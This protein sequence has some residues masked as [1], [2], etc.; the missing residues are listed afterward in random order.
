MVKKEKREAYYRRV[1]AN[2][3]F[4]IENVENEGKWYIQAINEKNKKVGRPIKIG[5]D[6]HKLLAKMFPTQFPPVDGFVAGQERLIRAD[7]RNITRTFKAKDWQDYG[8]KTAKAGKEF[9]KEIRTAGNFFSDPKTFSKVV[10]RFQGKTNEQVR[11]YLNAQSEKITKMFRNRIGTIKEAEVQTGYSSFAKAYEFNTIGNIARRP[12]GI[13]EYY[14]K[15]K[16]VIIKLVKDFFIGQH[17]G[18]KFF[19]TTTLD[20][21]NPLKPNANNTKDVKF[22]AKTEGILKHDFVHRIED[23]DLAVD[24]IIKNIINQIEKYTKNGSGFVVD[25][26]IKSFLNIGSYT[27]KNGRSFFKLDDYFMKRKCLFIPKNN[28]DLCAW[29]C[30]VYKFEAK[31][32]GINADRMSKLRA[33]KEKY[34]IDPSLF[35]LEVHLNSSR[36]Q[37][38]ENLFKTKINIYVVNTNKPKDVECYIAS[39]SNYDEHTDLL[40]IQNSESNER[41]FALI[42]DYN[43][44]RGTKKQTAFVCRN[45]DR[46][47]RRQETLKNHQDLCL[48]HRTTVIKMP[49]EENYIC[50]FKAHGNKQ[51]SPYTI[52]WDIE[53]YFMK[54]NQKK[55]KSSINVSEHIPS[56]VFAVVHSTFENKVIKTFYQRGEKCVQK[57]VQ[58]VTSYVDSLN[59]EFFNNPAPIIMTTDDHKNYE[60]STNCYLCLEEFCSEKIFKEYKKK[61]YEVLAH[62]KTIL[63]DEKKRKKYIKDNKPKCPKYKVRDHCHFTGKYRGSA[64]NDC[65]KIMRVKRVIP[66]VAHNFKGYDSHFIVQAL[67]K[68]DNFLVDVIPTNTEK[69]LQIST[70]IK[71]EFGESIKINFMDSMCHLSSSL[72]KLVKLLSDDDLVTTKEW[73]RGMSKD[74]DDFKVKF[75]LCKKKGDFSY[76]YF[77]CLEKYNETEIPEEKYFVSSLEHHG[78]KF[79]QLSLA[80]QMKIKLKRKRAV[81]VFKVF[82]FKNLWE[83]HDHYMMLD[84]YLLN[85]L[86]QAHRRMAFEKFG[87]D[88]C[89][90]PTL[91]SFCWDAMLKKTNVEL[92]LFKDGQ[93]DMYMFCER[94]KIGGISMVGS[95]AYSEA[96]HP[97]LS[98][99]DS[100]KPHKFIIYADVNGLYSWAMKQLLPYKDFRWIDLKN[101]DLKYA[102]ENA[103][104]ENGCFLDIDFKMPESLKDKFKCYPILPENILINNEMLS[105]FQHKIKETLTNFKSYHESGV[106]KLVPN[107]YDKKNYVIHIKHLKLVLDICG[108]AIDIDKDLTI[109][110]VLGFKQKAWLEPYISM[111]MNERAKKGI[112]DFEKDFW[113]LCSNA[114]YG[115]TM[116]DTRDRL[117]LKLCS[118]ENEIKERINDIRFNYFDILENGLVAIYK[119]KKQ[120]TLN[121]PIYAGVTVLNLSKCLMY[122][123]WYNKLQ[124]KY[125]KNIKLLYTDTDSFIFEVQTND[126]AKDV[127]TELWDFSNYPSNHP[128]FSLI[129]KKVE[130]KIKD[131]THGIPMAKL[132]ALRSKSYAFVMDNS[133]TKQQLDDNSSLE[134]CVGKGISKSILKTSNFDSYYRAKF[135]NFKKENMCQTVS[136]FGF[137]SNKHII[138]TVQVEK[139]FVSSFDDKRYWLDENGVNQVPHGYYK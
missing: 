136:M 18:V 84:V 41:H 100:N 9:V 68:D 19:L 122:D 39:R 113:K 2:K 92:E 75:E 95:Q 42:K 51:L 117:Y 129:N 73:I 110:K 123:L 12:N 119:Y 34:P 138:S 109:N 102:M 10:N 5:A 89:Y 104:S 3:D 107:L 118:D 137:Q 15:L 90:Y 21:I 32:I 91:P 106:K 80:D 97:L 28:D 72:D 83:W 93:E 66:A 88:P 114:V 98:T 30:L 121:K 59:K 130:G 1:Y 45:C 54:K 71:Q 128:L 24:R 49:S 63:N 8:F 81:E 105:P 69:F 52:S 4:R 31:N 11:K 58:E 112:S 67:K 33:F 124:K 44:F 131:E 126:F 60:S 13:Y 82:G 103:D 16:P 43:S 87:L 46:Q 40:L 57:F 22:R 25:R 61:L 64:C 135:H 111:C 120:T 47:F 85:D 134:K 79:N 139:Q 17:K 115:K 108:D 55:G 127:N 101:F 86:W 50:K 74:E 48:T 35:P 62:S 27:P 94:A 56:G 36:I 7:R 78:K 37:Q 76:E 20:F 77:D 96:N 70:T 53:T 38:L 99:Y 14:N 132:V 65:N 23:L 133:I 29:Y 116:E 6:A 26:I 125:G